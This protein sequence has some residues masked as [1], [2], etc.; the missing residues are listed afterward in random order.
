M[1]YTYA[2]ALEL[3]INKLSHNQRD[4][5]KSYRA[6][7]ETR[8]FGAPWAGYGVFVV[9]VVVLMTPIIL[10][11][12]E[13]WS[14]SHMFQLVIGILFVAAFPGLIAY[15]HLRGSIPSLEMPE[16][17]DAYRR[18]IEGLDAKAWYEMQAKWNFKCAYCG[19]GLSTYTGKSAHR[20]HVIPLSR[21]GRNRASNI[22]P[23]CSTCNLSKHTQT[24]S[25]YV[26]ARHRAGLSVN[27]DWEQRRR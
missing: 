19:M 25:E 21:G 7:Y 24:G 16:R 27:P 17:P 12:S 1:Y 20:E 23:S 18:P 13:A 9:T 2:E 11:T 5:V 26:I 8:Y 10:L 4:A 14:E 6:G 15:S 3:K 22:V